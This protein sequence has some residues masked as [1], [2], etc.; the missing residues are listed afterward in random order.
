MD[1][2]RRLGWFIFFRILVVT[3]LLGSTS[4]LN[5][6]EAGSSVYPSQMT[7][8]RLIAATYLFSIGSYL[9]L[10]TTDRYTRFLTYLQ[11]IWDL[12]FV[13]LLLL[14]TGGITSP[15]SFLYFLSIINASVL[16]A[17]REAFYTASLCG[18]LYGAILDFQ[19]FGKL[20]N[21]GLSPLP[22]QQ[23]GTKFVFSTIFLNFGAFFLTAFLSGYLAE[24]ARRSESALK[25]K[26]IDFEELERLNSSIV[27]NIGSGLLTV[28]NGGR[29]RV[30]NRYVQQLTGVSLEDAYDR[31]LSEIITPFEAYGER[32]LTPLSGEVAYQ[33]GEGKK[34][35]IGF[36]SVPLTDLQGN[37]QGA[38]I[39]LLDLTQIKQ[40]EAELKKADR[41]AAIG[42][43]SARIAHEI[44]NP[45]ASISGSV[46]LIA[47][48]GSVSEGDKR[49]LA[50]VERESDRLNL[51]INDFLAYARPAA[52]VKT[53]VA[54]HDFVREMQ[55]LVKADG[56]FERV[57][58]RNDCLPGIMVHVDRDQ[59]RQVFWNLLVNAADAMPDGGTVTFT[60][61][62][63]K[64]NNGEQ[65][66][67][68]K[69]IVE[70]NGK[71]I[72]EQVT[73]RI[74]E[75]FFTTK[76][77][78]TGLGLATVYRIIEAHGGKIQMESTVGSGTIFTIILPGT[79]FH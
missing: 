6:D 72:E 40:M 19:Y 43:L 9:L 53:A 60:A 44:R 4:I 69:V 73:G 58:L 21:L 79:R 8:V 54:I 12:I 63:E 74:F 78:G 15:Y 61:V 75:P 59:F 41:L 49:L 35:V 18:I 17:R 50:I 25:K 30:F 10:K 13:T 77:G 22:A 51:L 56:R 36:K 28:T 3:V 31:P 67:F 48:G 55:A 34:L 66:D 46:Q 45:L 37:R 39:N 23:L 1:E 2:K 33:S 38:I 68:V 27:S 64:L 29:V 26:V 16:L 14:I 32:V 57:I 20:V 5:F 65:G 62:Y 70:D 24:R 71:G 76:N 11:I 42:E 52:P 7:V 47:Q